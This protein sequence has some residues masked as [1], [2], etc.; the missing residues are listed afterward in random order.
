VI[1]RLI[2]KKDFKKF[3]PLMFNPTKEKGISYFC[4]LMPIY[5]LKQNTAFVKKKEKTP[6]K[7][8]ISAPH[9]SIERR[10]SGKKVHSL[11]AHKQGGAEIFNFRFRIFIKLFNLVCR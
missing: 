5:K 6:H 3:T 1:L 4:S 9:S 8:D 2:D 7:L 10:P 11:T